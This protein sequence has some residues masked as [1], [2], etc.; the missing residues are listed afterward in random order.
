[1]PL[2]AQALANQIQSATGQVPPAPAQLLSYCRGF[3]SV[4]K[5][6][7]VAAPLVSGTTAAGAPLAAGA[8]PAA[9]AT[10]QPTPWLAESGSLG[11][12]ASAEH[13]AIVTYVM[14]GVIVFPPGTVTGQCTSTP[15]SPG[16][17]VN[18]AAEGGRFTGLA[19]AACAS[20]VAGATGGQL[21][22]PDSI[23]VYDAMMSYVMLS[24]KVSFPT[25]TI[26]G[27]CPPGAGSLI[28]TGAGG[29]IT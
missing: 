5:A 9:I 18:G 3:I 17:L 12:L 15:T 25:G 20:A 26:T 2:E 8:I 16:P 22:G 19:G 7:I 13:T 28:G 10:L 4:L 6:G 1:M 27:V 14:T 24:A 11:P 29:L 21:A 23:K